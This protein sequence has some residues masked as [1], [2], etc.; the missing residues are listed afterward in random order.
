VCVTVHG[1]DRGDELRDAIAQDVATVVERQDQITLYATGIGFFSHAVAKADNEP[2]GTYLPSI[3]YRAI[4]SSKEMTH[5]R[6]TAKCQTAQPHCP[7]GVAGSRSLTV[8]F[9]S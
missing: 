6:L 5:R 4:R 3:G 8:Q 9:S 7:N 2:R 1:L